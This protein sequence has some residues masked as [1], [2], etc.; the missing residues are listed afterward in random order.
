MENPN[1]N[2]FSAY[3]RFKSFG[4]AFRGIFSMFIRQP[5]FLVQFSIAVL[6]VIAGFAFD[7]SSAEWLFVVLAIGLVLSLEM[8][9]TVVEKLVDMVS[10]EYN[11]KAGL[12]KDIAAG[13]V[14]VAAIT[15][16]VIG[17]IIFLPHLLKLI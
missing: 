12:I 5:N 14:L 2:R 17:L 8:F 11:Q 9:N 1:D 4:Y 10:P 15:A 6:V 13:A 3:Q 7:I 16:A